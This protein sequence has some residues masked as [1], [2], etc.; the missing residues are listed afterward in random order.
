LAPIAAATP[1]YRHITKYQI[2]QIKCLKKNLKSLIF[3]KN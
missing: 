1:I 3:M 2:K